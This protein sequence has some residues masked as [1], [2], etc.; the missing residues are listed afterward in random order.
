[1]KTTKRGTLAWA[2]LA[3][4]MLPVSVVRAGNDDGIL[5][6]GQAALT[7]GAVTAI[8][9][10]GAAAWYNPAGLARITR[11]SFDINASAYGISLISADN[12]F[13]LPNGQTAS[14]DA[15]DW[16]LIPT[17]LSYS[18]V[19]S[20]RVV[21]SFGVFIPYTTDLDLRAS[22]TQPDGTEWLI[23]LDQ[24]RNEYDYIASIGVR[25]SETLRVGVAL[26]GIYVSLENN[27]QLASGTPGLSERTFLSTSQHEVRG[28]YGLRLAVGVQWTPVARLELGVSAQTPTLTGFRRIASDNVSGLYPGGMQGVFESQHV[29]GVRQP[30]DLSTPFLLR[31]GAAYRVGRAQ[32]LADGSLSSPLDTEGTSL[33]RRLSGNA[34]VGVLVH[35]SELL[36]YGMGAFSDRNGLREAYANFYGV[37]GGVRMASNYTISEGQRQLTFATTLAGRYAY[38]AGKA[39]AASLDQDVQGD[40]PYADLRVHE[41]AFN[42][43][44]GVTF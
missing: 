25:V 24:V 3:A 43:G 6:G 5:V 7:G 12:L 39:E 17:A 37:S 34:R 33:D 30:W 26:H 40:P 32:L 29:D 4:V 36:S 19:L 16:Q 9:S 38:G 2:L 44:G 1:M 13:T 20:A 10:D 27:V 18:R 42:L 31:A 22:I 41:L 8:A 35:H 11:H 23:G 15:V 21:G 28:E 14:A